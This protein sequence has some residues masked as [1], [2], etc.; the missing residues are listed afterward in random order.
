VVGGCCLN[1]NIV[2]YEDGDLLLS[3]A[4]RGLSSVALARCADG[5]CLE[6]V[7]LQ[8]GVVP[9]AQLRVRCVELVATATHL[10]LAGGGAAAPSD[11]RPALVRRPPVFHRTPTPHRLM[12]SPPLTSYH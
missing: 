10:L 11:T 4:P 8:D 7:E 6:A 3:Q 1:A 12:H 5:V 9:A 2:I